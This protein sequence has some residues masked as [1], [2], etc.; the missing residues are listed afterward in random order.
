[1]ITNTII[2][3]LAFVNDPVINTG[4]ERKEREREEKEGIENVS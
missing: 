2:I 4:L 1:M 3:F